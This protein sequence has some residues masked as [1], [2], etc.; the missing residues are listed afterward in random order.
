MRFTPSVLALL[1]GLALAAPTSPGASASPS[2]AIELE[3]Q[4][5]PAEKDPDYGVCNG[6]SCKIGIFNWDCD[7]GKCTVQNG[8][9]DGKPCHRND[10]KI[11]C[12]GRE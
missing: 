9:G 3:P 8:G 11:Y 10:G 7:V 6:T 5:K 2:S 1:A 4:I 12:P